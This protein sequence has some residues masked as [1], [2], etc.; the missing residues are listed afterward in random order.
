MPDTQ[1]LCAQALLT[2]HKSD[3]PCLSLYTDGSYCPKRHLGGWGVWLES[4]YDIP[5]KQFLQGAH[6]STS[7]LEM[8]LTAAIH[9]LNYAA[10]LCNK[11]PAVTFHILLLTDSKIL[12]EAMEYKI[13]RYK[14]QHWQHK[15]GRPVAFKPLWL[16]FEHL[17]LALN[18]ELQWVKGH[19]HSPGN[20]MADQLARAALEEYNNRPDPTWRH[21]E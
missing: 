14:Q 6:P 4:Q 20:C 13:E 7:S 16:A 21:P 10:D 8:E 12:L 11:N 5:I 19:S 18:A 2:S 9:A 17:M 1:S 15:S 3:Q